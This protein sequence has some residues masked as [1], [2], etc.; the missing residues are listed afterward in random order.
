MIN[1]ALINELER[2]EEPGPLIAELHRRFPGR[3][4]IG[5]S[6]QLT[7]C[8]LIDLAVQAGIKPRVF[9]IDT[10]RLFPETYAL[11]DAL[12]KRYGIRIERYTPDAADLG[13]MI[14]QHGEFLFFDSKEKQELCCSI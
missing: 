4:A 10:L 1:S 6:G 5:T 13:P 2:I 8:A 14:E 9:T 12:E 7:G 3:T 11:F